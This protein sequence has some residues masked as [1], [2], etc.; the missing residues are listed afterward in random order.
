MI[1]QKSSCLGLKYSTKDTASSI[2]KMMSSYRTNT[3]PLLE[4]SLEMKVESNLNEQAILERWNLQEETFFDVSKEE[5]SS[6]FQKI[7]SYD[8]NMSP[9]CS[10]EDETVLERTED[11]VFI[12]DGIPYN[13]SGQQL[14]SSTVVSND[15]AHHYTFPTTSDYDS[16]MM[17]GLTHRPH[18]GSEEQVVPNISS[19]A[20]G[21]SSE[22]SPTGS[23]AK[24]L[25]NL[26]LRE[27]SAWSEPPPRV[28]LSSESDFDEELFAELKGKS[29]GKRC[30]GKGRA[31]F[32]RLR[33][34]SDLEYLKRKREFEARNKHNSEERFQ[35]IASLDD[36]TRQLLEVDI[37][38][39]LSLFRLTSG[40]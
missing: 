8:S 38:K 25:V 27:I 7:F 21:N 32:K 36:T 20:D 33:V 22:F 15:T 11:T 3:T 5:T 29:N 40:E 2:R 18:Q 4:P 31:S 17:P 13:D 1:V 9:L 39:P 26:F 16:E 10:S 34:S 35:G 28:R 12:R 23:R 30:F 14:L 6:T 24:M 37:V 19:T